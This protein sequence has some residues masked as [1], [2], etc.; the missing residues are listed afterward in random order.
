MDKFEF[1]AVLVSI[2]FGVAITNLL[3]GVLEHHPLSTGSLNIPL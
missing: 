2:V 3:S 1:V